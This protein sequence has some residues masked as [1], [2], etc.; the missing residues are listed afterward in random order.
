MY[1]ARKC[2]KTVTLL[3]CNDLALYCTVATRM[4]RT[5]WQPMNLARLSHSH[6]CDNLETLQAHLAKALRVNA[7]QSCEFCT[8]SLPLVKINLMYVVLSAICCKAWRL[9]KITWPNDHTIDVKHRALTLL[10][11]IFQSNYNALNNFSAISHRSV[12]R[13]FDARLLIRGF[14]TSTSYMHS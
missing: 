5:V 12:I 8:A 13:R 14:G 2:G 11:P 4:P 7:R 3:P 9:R 1:F 10:E 6:T